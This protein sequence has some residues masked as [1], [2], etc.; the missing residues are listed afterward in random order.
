MGRRKGSKNGQ[1]TLISVQCQKCSRTFEI[2]PYQKHRKYCSHKCR[3]L[4]SENDEN[5]AKSRRNYLKEQGICIE[6]GSNPATN[7]TIRCDPCR[8]KQSKNNLKWRSSHPELKEAWKKISISKRREYR[9]TWRRNTRI[10][11]I[12]LYGGKCDCCGETTLEFLQFHHIEKNGKK[13][14]AE[15]KNGSRMLRDLI[16]NFGKYKVQILC[17]NCHNAITVYGECP[18]DKI[19]KIPKDVSL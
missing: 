13:H 17:S 5:K 8:D 6:C 7:N 11:A 19:Q 1:R 10:K 3:R 9:K 15:S 12:Q 16:K 18:H 14:R 4:Y 2:E